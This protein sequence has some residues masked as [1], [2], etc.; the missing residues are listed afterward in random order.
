MYKVHEQTIRLRPIM[1]FSPF[2]MLF[3][4]G[5]HMLQK[6]IMLI[7]YALFFLIYA[8]IHAPFWWRDY[9]PNAFLCYHIML[10]FGG[11]TSPMLNKVIK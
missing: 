5:K 10:V 9:A 8:P 3:F 6:S 4:F 7:I 2:F 11:N 1:L